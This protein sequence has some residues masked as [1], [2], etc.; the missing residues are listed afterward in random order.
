MN[1][2][3]LYGIDAVGNEYE[4][5]FDK[6][7]IPALKNRNSKGAVIFGATIGKMA[8][9]MHRVLFMVERL[10]KEPKGELGEMD[11]EFYGMLKKN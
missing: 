2:A 5:M 11:K 9:D 10:S 3:I 8:T 4:E 6:V 7:V 1:D